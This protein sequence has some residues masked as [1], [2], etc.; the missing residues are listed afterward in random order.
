MQIRFYCTKCLSLLIKLFIVWYTY[1]SRMV[2]IC[3]IYIYIFEGN[4]WL[5]RKNVMS[6]ESVV[7]QEFFL[8]RDIFEKKPVILLPKR[9]GRRKN[10][11]SLLLNFN[12][13]CI[14]SNKTFTSL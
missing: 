5:V 7:I 1:L 2:H 6:F 11:G 9:K 12:Q 4:I 10:S 3:T 8:K 13:A 14:V